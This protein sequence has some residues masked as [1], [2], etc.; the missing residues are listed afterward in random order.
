MKSDYP[1][2][3]NPM[4]T[5]IFDA[6]LPQVALILA[7]WDE[8][9]PAIQSFN[10]YFS[11]A[12][13]I[14]RHQKAGVWMGT[15]GLAPTP[16]LEAVL[17][18]PLLNLMQHTDLAALTDAKPTERVMGVGSALFQLLAAQNELGEALNLNGDLIHDLCDDSVVSIRSDG[19]AALN[20]MFASVSFSSSKTSIDQQM[21]KFNRT[22]TI[23]DEDFRPPTFRREHPSQVPPSDPIPVTIPSG[24]KRIGDQLT[25]DEKPFKRAKTEVIVRKKAG[26]KEAKGGTVSTTPRRLRSGKRV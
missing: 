2:H 22:H 5:A 18:A 1:D 24:M 23:F 11:G 8:K 3:K 15:F 21:L 17:S 26:P 14:E 9:H 25:G 20:A 4:L 6:A 16:E 12:K 13:S 19:N 7:I 10:K